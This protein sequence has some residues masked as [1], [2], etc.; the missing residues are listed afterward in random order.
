[1]VGAATYVHVVPLKVRGAG[2]A[3]YRGERL[4]L[5]PHHACAVSTINVIVR[6]P[7]RSME[8]TRAAGIFHAAFTL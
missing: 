5:V 4:L 3:I 2:S 8:T 7:D 1:V 6:K